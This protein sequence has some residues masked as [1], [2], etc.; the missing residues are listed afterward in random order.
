MNDTGDGCY[1]TTKQL[2]GATGLSERAVCEHIG[3]AADAGWL[4]VSVHGFKGQKWKNHQY[5]AAWP[6]EG[7]TDPDDRKALTEG[8]QQGTGRISDSRKGAD[9]RSKRH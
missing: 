4:S 1:P 6:E 3:K 5:Q 9:P 2:A 7:D 8:Q